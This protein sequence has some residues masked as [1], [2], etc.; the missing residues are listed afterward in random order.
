M[1]NELLKSTIINAANK[2]EG[3]HDDTQIEI[4]LKPSKFDGYETLVVTFLDV[5]VDSYDVSE[6]WKYC[7]CHC[8]LYFYETETL[9]EMTTHMDIDAQFAMDEYDRDYYT[10]IWNEN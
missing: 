6:G 7:K 2:E 3:I 8:E 9:P 1:D 10:D 4:S 5:R